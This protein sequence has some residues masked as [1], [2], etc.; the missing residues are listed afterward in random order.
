ML[1]QS[2][3]A[4]VANST[5]SMCRHGPRRRITSV[6][7][8]PMIVSARALSYASP[9]L[10][11]ASAMPASASRDA[12]IRVASQV[13][14]K[15]EIYDLFVILLQ[16]AVAHETHDAWFQ[17]LED[18]LTN[19]ATQL[20]G[21]P[22]ECLRMF[23]DQLDEIATVLPVDSWFQVRARSITSSGIA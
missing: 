3:H 2:T 16:A 20:P 11:T 4:S 5:A 22:S 10:P 18:Q 19:I 17:W 1:N 14:E 7:N 12:V 15:K 8:R 13:T 21:P 9:R 6:L 23:Q